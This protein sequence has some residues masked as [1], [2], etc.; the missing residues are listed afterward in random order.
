VS[1]MLVW[2]D[3]SIEFVEYSLGKMMNVL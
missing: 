1:L 2:Y 3:S